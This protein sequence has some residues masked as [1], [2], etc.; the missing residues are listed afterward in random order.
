M[1]PE[2]VEIPLW[3]REMMAKKSAEKAKRMA[4]KE[5]GNELE[6]RKMASIPEWKRQLLQK[7]KAEADDSKK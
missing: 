6:S 5:H 4:V 2:G 3:K 7:H 1:D